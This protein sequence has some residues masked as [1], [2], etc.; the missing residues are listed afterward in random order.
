MSH[1]ISYLDNKMVG[2]QYRSDDTGNIGCLKAIGKVLKVMHS[3][4]SMVSGYTCNTTVDTW[5]H[6]VVI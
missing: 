5:I 3:S 2:T 1:L 6:V 4:E